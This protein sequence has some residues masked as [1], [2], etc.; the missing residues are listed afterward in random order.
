MKDNLQARHIQEKSV[1][2]DG[3]GVYLTFK[4]LQGTQ[5]RS[6]QYTKTISFYLNLYECVYFT[7]LVRCT[8][9][10]SSFTGK[11]L[12]IKRNF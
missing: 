10:D 12:K 1:L 7:F 6:L 3:Q 8:F 5:K 11:A 4:Y 2:H 9:I